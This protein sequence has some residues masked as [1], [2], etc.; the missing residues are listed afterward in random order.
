MTAS[1][2]TLLGR[3]ADVE[4]RLADHAAAPLPSGLT[5]PDPGAEERWEAGQVWAHLAEFPAYWLGQA[6]RVVALPTNEPVPFGRVKTDVLRVE[7]IERDRHESPAALLERVRATLAEV[8]DAARAFTPEEWRRRGQHPT[9]GVMTVERI[10]EKFI[11][12]HLEEHADQLDQLRA[13][14][15]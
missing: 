11:V 12:D 2:D 13:G 10:L 5:E 14:P 1:V 9:R 7:A 4:R 8:G 15:G 3:L 6:R